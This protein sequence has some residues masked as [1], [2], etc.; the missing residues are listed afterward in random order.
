MQDRES[1]FPAQV[2]PPPDNYQPGSRN[3][4]S[5]VTVCSERFEHG[6]DHHRDHDR[7]R[8]LIDNPVEFL[9]MPVAI[10]GEIARPAGEKAVQ[11]GECDRQ[12][13]LRLEPPGRIPTTTPGEPQT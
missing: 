7:G 8:Y 1:R 3:R 10:R 9:G 6:E 11:C 12:S 13:D 5:P 4:V 2:A